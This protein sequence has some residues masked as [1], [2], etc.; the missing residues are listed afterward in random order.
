IKILRG[1]GYVVA[2]SKSARLGTFEGSLSVTEGE[3]ETNIPELKNGLGAIDTSKVD[4][5]T[6]S[7]MNYGTSIA[8]IGVIHTGVTVTDVDVLRDY[9]IHYIDGAIVV[10]D[11]DSSKHE[12]RGETS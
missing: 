10:Y 12:Y 1:D 8:N 6:N 5:I 3:I 9:T 2:P 11:D 7:D 4:L